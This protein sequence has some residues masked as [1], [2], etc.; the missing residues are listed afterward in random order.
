MTADPSKIQVI[1]DWPMPKT[2]K[3]LRGFLGLTGYYRRFVKGYGV[4]ARPLTDLLKKDKFEWSGEATVAFEQLKA[5][6]TTTPVLAL[7]NFALEFV[8]ETDACG[9]GIGAVLMQADHPLAYMSKAL[10]SK[11]LTLSVYEKQM[12][13]IVTAIDK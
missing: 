12:L 9:L 11:H 2:V 13:E 7:P 6:M 10:G 5:A 3:E 8:I 1:K 4:M